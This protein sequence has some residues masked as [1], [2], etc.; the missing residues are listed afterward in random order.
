M[1]QIT[2]AIPQI[3]RSVLT[4]EEY[5]KQK[6]DFY[7]SLSGNLTGYDCKKCLKPEAKPFRRWITHEVLP[8]IRRTGSYSLIEPRKTK[9][10]YGVSV[11]TIK[12]VAERMRTSRDTARKRI[13]S[14]LRNG[15]DF[16]ILSEYSLQLFK[17]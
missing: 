14:N 13:F 6:V 17:F 11:L 12:D 15:F 7:N 9:T 16:F 1:E 10:W 8:K 3:K 4:Y 2:K 5:L